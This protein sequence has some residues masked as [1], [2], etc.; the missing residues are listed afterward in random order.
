MSEA[1]IDAPVDGDA[2]EPVKAPATAGPLA[3]YRFVLS[4]GFAAAV[5][6]QPLID[7]VQTGE[8]I[9]YALLRVLAAATLMWFPTGLINRLLANAKVD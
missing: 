7:A 2:A 5:A 9:E 6:G 8:R 4:V 3:P 1:T